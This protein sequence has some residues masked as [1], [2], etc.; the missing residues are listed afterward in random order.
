MKRRDTAGTWQWHGRHAP[1]NAAHDEKVAGDRDATAKDGGMAAKA[2]GIMAKNKGMAATHVDGMACTIPE[3]T[4][5]AGLYAHAGNK[6]AG[7]RLAETGFL[8]L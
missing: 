7:F 5:D 6:K 3:Y 2:G 4:G 1:S 8:S